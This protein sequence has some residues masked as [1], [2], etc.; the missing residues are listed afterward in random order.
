MVRVPVHDHLVR[1]GA[2]HLLDKRAEEIKRLIAKGVVGEGY[3]VRVLFQIKHQL[4]LQLQVQHVYCHDIAVSRQR[5]IIRIIAACVPSVSRGGV[6]VS[7]LGYRGGSPRHV[8]HADH[9]LYGFG[10]GRSCLHAG[11]LG[12][13]V[14]FR[15]V[16]LKISDL[17][18]QAHPSAIAVRGTEGI[19][20][21]FLGEIPVH[22]Q[23]PTRQR[24]SIRTV[25][26]SFQAQ[27]SRI[28]FQNVLKGAEIHFQHVH[29][30]HQ[31]GQV[32]TDAGVR[33]TK[34][35]HEFGFGIVLRVSVFRI[36]V[37][38]IHV[39]LQDRGDL[40]L[41]VQIHAERGPQRILQTCFFFR[42][43]HAFACR[44][45]GAHV[46]PEGKIHHVGQNARKI[47]P[48]DL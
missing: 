44:F 33:I 19:S 42:R 40:L 11:I 45:G 21:L 43:R 24:G 7:R 13:S 36:V 32:Q 48:R 35:K 4:T 27:A 38:R 25:V 34:S 28:G 3:A 37:D 41:V 6:P 1:F 23:R 16:K 8:R 20:F 46:I 22:V 31:E 10:I 5:L 15:Q 26:V 14:L 30:R 12:H 29:H 9:R 47:Q 17:Y 39:L 2:D 18:R